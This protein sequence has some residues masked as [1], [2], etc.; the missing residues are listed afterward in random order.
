VQLF[1]LDTTTD[2]DGP[3]AN[4][5][6]LGIAVCAHSS[7]S[8]T[9]AVVSDLGVTPTVPINRTVALA[10]LEYRRGHYDRAVEW[11][12]RC[13]GGYPDYTAA[14]VAT[15]HALLAMSYQKLNQIQEAKAE[16]A[17]SAEMIHTKFSSGLDSGDAAQGFWQDWVLA[18]AVLSEARSVTG[19]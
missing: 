8:N 7:V 10:L 14:R 2:P 11:C 12:R 9:T 18:G 19:Q 16:L 17:K 5:I 13:L 4:P 3:F 6:H 1:Q 15:A